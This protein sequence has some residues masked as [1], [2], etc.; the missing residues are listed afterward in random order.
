MLCMSTN[1]LQPSLSVGRLTKINS[2]CCNA[3]NSYHGRPG[4]SSL[5]SLFYAIKVSTI[6][7]AFVALGHLLNHLLSQSADFSFYLESWR[8]HL[9]S[10][11]SALRNPLKDRRL[12]VFII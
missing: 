9:H 10:L 6:K 3:I 11:Y 8:Y 5:V 7:S 1:T 2:D 12:E 4:K